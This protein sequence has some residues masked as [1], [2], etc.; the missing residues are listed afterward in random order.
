[1]K[2]PSVLVVRG[3]GAH[4]INRGKIPQ[5]GERQMLNIPY[6]VGTSIVIRT[7]AYHYIGT[8][9]QSIVGWVMLEPAV[10]LAD[11]GRWG[12]FLATGLTDRTEVEPYPAECWIPTHRILDAS[13]W[14]H[15]VPR[16]AK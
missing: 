3:H 14:N 8:I 1:M 5:P 16:E 11:S 13:T 15:P 2:N 7:D 4:P 12:E 9:A 6:E 10:W